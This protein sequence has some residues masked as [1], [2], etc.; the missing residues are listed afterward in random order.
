MLRLLA[1][2]GVDG[3]IIYE[4]LGPSKCEKFDPHLFRVHAMGE[5]RRRGL[6]GVPAG[7]TRRKRRQMM[8]DL[9]RR[10]IDGDDGSIFG[11]S[12][13]DEDEVAE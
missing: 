8:D 9:K 13:R 3:P 10:G 2:D 1:R 7:F 4:K 6:Q 12:T 11:S 5:K